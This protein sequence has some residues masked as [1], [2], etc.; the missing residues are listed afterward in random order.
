MNRIIY[1]FYEWIQDENLDQYLS[2]PEGARG[3]KPDFPVAF[4]EEHGAESVDL[5]RLPRTMQVLY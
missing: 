5:W 2:T 3:D 4:C 1:T